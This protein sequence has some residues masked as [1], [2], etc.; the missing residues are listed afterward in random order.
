M[1]K[2][3][4]SNKPAV[5]KFYMPAVTLLGHERGIQERIIAAV[6]PLEKEP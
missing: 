4:S 3:W 6:H 1:S 2:I 5:F